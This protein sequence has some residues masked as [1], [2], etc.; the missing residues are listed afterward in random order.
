MY[1]LSSRRRML[2][3]N[4]AV[5]TGVGL[6]LSLG[7]AP[8]QAAITDP[9]TVVSFTFDDGNA[10]Q[11]AALPIFD[12]AGMK[13]TFFIATGWIGAQDY[14]TQADLATL[15]AGGH[16]IGGHTVSHPDLTLVPADEVTKQI[17]Q[18]RNTLAGWGYPTTD[19]AYPY[20][21]LNPAVS[22]AVQACGFNSARNLGDTFTRFGGTAGLFAETIPPLNAFETRAPDE[23]DST[24]TLADLQKTVTD[25]ETAGGGWVQL[26]LHHVCTGACDPLNLTI[27]PTLLQQ[28]VDWLKLRAATNNTTVKTVAQVI[29]GAVKP[30]VTSTNTFRAAPGPGEN[31]VLNPSL[32]TP[33]AVGQTPQCWQPGG[34]GISTR[35]FSTVTAAHTGTAAEQLVVTGL[36][37][38]DAKLALT[39]DLGT[40]APTATPG[41]TYS[42]RAWYTSTANTQFDVYYRNAVGGWIYWTSGPQYLPSTTYTQVAWDTP[43]VPAGSTGLSFGLNLISNGTLVTDDYAL[44]DTVGA[45]ATAVTSAIPT[46]SGVPGVGLVLTALPGVWAPATVTFAYQWF[47]AGV[48]VAG[49]TTATYTPVLGDVGK[50]VTVTI[51]GSQTGLPSVAASSPATTPV[52][53]AAAATVARLWGPDAYGTS[54][55]VS[56]GSFAAGVPVAYVATGETYQDALSGAPAAGVNKGPVLLVQQNGIPGVIAAELARLRPARIVVLGGNLAV[57]DGVFATL[58]GLAPTTRLWGP[59]AYGTSA[60]VS[61][62]TFAPGVPVAYIATG[63]TYQDALSGAP[64]AGINKGPV[65]LV[66]PNGIPGVIATELAR[67]RPARI[68]ILGGNLAISDGVAAALAGIAPTTRLW[69]PDA[70]GTSAAVSAGTFATGVPVVYLATGATYQDALSGGSAAVVNGGPV[71]LVQPNGIPAVIGAELTRLKPTKIVILGGN[72]A[73]S[74]SVM[75]QALSLAK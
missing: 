11:M 59:D 62:G 13:G 42:L 37:T 27:T 32:E 24:W 22:A 72:L 35:T 52:A 48:A 41:H 16:E 25:A 12:S 17:C 60:A 74:D 36:V 29:G 26:T 49:A 69:G 2:L 46:I 64:A 18:G 45:P 73:I 1:E 6:A 67:L 3:R 70:Y 54:A 75:A 66:Q 71:L 20:A 19:F 50:A 56:A 34:F 10:D 31:A 47:V 51:T 28:F 61:A 21:S 55:A 4:M 65:L 63:D 39:Q 15:K 23:I 40:C 5:L 7:M 44:Y 30:L 38:G 53:P 68:I 14:M 33:G 57:S 43:P 9:P 8:A 58:S